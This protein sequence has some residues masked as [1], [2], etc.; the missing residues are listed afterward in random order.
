M[1][2][3]YRFIGT[4]SEIHGVAELKE[5]GQSVQLDEQLFSEAIKGGCA[6]VPSDDFDAAGFTPDELRKYKYAGPRQS[7]H[8]EFKGKLAELHAALSALQHEHGH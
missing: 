3:T 8:E 2:N 5:L 7:A 4:Y 1:K 6:I